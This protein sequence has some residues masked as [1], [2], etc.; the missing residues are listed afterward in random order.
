[1]LDERYIEFVGMWPILDTSVPWRE[2]RR[3]ALDDLDAAAKRTGALRVLA[4]NPPYTV[5]ASGPA[6]PHGK[7]V[8]IDAAVVIPATLA[9]EIGHRP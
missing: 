6:F 2:L 4:H 7:A 9:A 1:M 8:R 5:D 3:E